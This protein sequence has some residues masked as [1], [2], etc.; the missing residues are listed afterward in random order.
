MVENPKD[1]ENSESPEPSESYRGQ[2]D[3]GEDAAAA[4]EQL[5]F[6]KDVSDLAAY[7][8]KIQ[9]KPNCSK[10]T[11]KEPKKE[12][13]DMDPMND[14]FRPDNLDEAVWDT[15]RIARTN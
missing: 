1:S 15:W 14:L 3:N 7:I 11:F 12:L 9:D 8:K 10:R 2:P 5:E 4:Y 6:D 13:A